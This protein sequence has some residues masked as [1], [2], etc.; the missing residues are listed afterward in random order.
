VTLNQ[1]KSRLI[2]PYILNLLKTRS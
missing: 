1:S 2:I